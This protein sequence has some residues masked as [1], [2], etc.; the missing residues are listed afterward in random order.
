MGIK[1]AKAP[2]YC[3]EMVS[4]YDY[5]DDLRARWGWEVEIVIGMTELS[6][7]TWERV[8]K[9]RIQWKNRTTQ[10]ELKDDLYREYVIAKR[11]DQ[12][13]SGVM[14]DLC[15]QFDLLVAATMAQGTRF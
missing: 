11:P 1:D 5:L 9:L 4:V 14:W 3:V 13:I 2:K 10:G 15:Y 12:E 7:N 8:P 6:E